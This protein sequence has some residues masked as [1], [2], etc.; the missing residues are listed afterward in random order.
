MDFRARTCLA[1]LVSKLCSGPILETVNRLGIFND[2]KHYVDMPL[3]KS[4]GKTFGYL[5]GLCVVQCV[6]DYCTVMDSMDSI[7]V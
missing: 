2:S 5:A 7:M 3:K 4:Q 6:H 1:I